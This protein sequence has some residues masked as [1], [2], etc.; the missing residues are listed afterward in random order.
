M[1]AFEAVVFDLYGTLVH[2]IPRATFFDVVHAMAR[3]LGVDGDS[4][5]SEWT[6][7]AIERQTGGHPTVADNIRAIA[8]R[9]ELDVDGRALERA[10]ALRDAMY[11][12]HFRARPG[13]EETLS[14]LRTRG[15]PIAL[16]SMCA[17]DTPALWVR[18]PLA[19]LVDVTVFSCEVGLRKP[20]PEIYRHASDA[21]GVEPP[22]CLYVG[23]GAYGEMSGA[24]A[25]G[26]YPVLIRDRHE[27]PGSALR[28]EAEHWPGRRT[29]HLTDV[30]SLVGERPRESP[31]RVRSPEAGPVRSSAE[32]RSE[33][34][35]PRAR[36]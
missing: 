34:T 13:A 33:T 21:L 7:T 12:T 1:R 35:P 9:L 25:V 5:E 8:A 11:A 3:E 15:L 26:M 22:G 20:D 2:E 24:A 30:L 28:P 14:V 4:F 16:V 27:Q 19:G 31:P 17:P 10:L 23:D 18:S 32:S 6:A 29:F 36:S